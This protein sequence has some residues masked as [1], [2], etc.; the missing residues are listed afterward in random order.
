MVELRHMEIKMLGNQSAYF[1]GK[2]ENVLINPS[3]EMLNSSKLP[4][5]IIVLTS[6]KFDGF[7]L[8]NDVVVI[9]GPG[10]Y[11]VGGVEIN[12]FSAG[13]GDFMYTINHDGLTIGVLGE[14]TEVLS[15]KRVEKINGVDV[16]LAPVSIKGESSAKVVLDWAKKWGVNYLLPAGWTEN[17]T[18]LNKFLD[19][20]DQE[21]LEKTDSLKIDS[22]NLPDGLEIKVLK[23]V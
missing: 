22:N 21:G 15:D 16:L 5:R 4:S 13:N 1:K 14:L 9:R 20:A 3:A 11:E 23:K 7:G 2:K 10:E 8:V 6:D 18:E 19:I 12:G 17:E